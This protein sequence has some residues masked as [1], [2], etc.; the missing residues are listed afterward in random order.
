MSAGW[1]W[2]DG[3]LLPVRA[4]QSTDTTTFINP[5]VHLEK[6]SFFDPEG[7]RDFVHADLS[8]ET[9][10]DVRQDDYIQPT[11]VESSAAITTGVHIL[12][13][14]RTLFDDMKMHIS[15]SES[16][17]IQSSSGS[18]SFKRIGRIVVLK[19]TPPSYTINY[20]GG[21]VAHHGGTYA[22]VDN[23]FPIPIG[24]EIATIVPVPA[25][26]NGLRIYIDT[27]GR[28][29]CNQVGT[30]GAEPTLPNLTG[31]V[32]M[33]EQLYVSTPVDT[34]VIYCGQ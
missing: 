20:S 10:A 7:T 34:N 12:P 4:L 33:A 30:L 9:V 26:G 11:V 6:A 25:T 2:W 3:E 1:F 5:I 16:G 27:Q 24:G 22:P 29:F 23:G 28:L 31:M 18:M 32:Y 8:T 19:G 21:D 13:G 14:A 15:D 17:W